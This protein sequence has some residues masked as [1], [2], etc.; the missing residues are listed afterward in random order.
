MASVL[1]VW[2]FLQVVF[3]NRERGRIKA[4]KEGLA[5]YIQELQLVRET[6]FRTAG[7][8]QRT[9][10]VDGRVLVPFQDFISLEPFMEGGYQESPGL[11]SN[12]FG[13]SLGFNDE[14][15][16]EAS[17]TTDSLSSDAW[18]MKTS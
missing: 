7:Y 6:R 2:H 13:G 1:T 16:V 17:L 4:R 12:T 15:A 8:C 10:S 5:G 14:H 11:R 9:M 18:E 3:G